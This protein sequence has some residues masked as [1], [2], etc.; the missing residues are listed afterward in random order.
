MGGIVKKLQ[1]VR[2]EVGPLR[3][4]RKDR[5]GPGLAMSRSLGDLEAHEVG[6]VEVPGRL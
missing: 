4:W 1:G 3:V 2:G 5:N 6:V